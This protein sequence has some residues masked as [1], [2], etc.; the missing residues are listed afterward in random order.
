MISVFKKSAILA[1]FSLTTSTIAAGVTD[2]GTLLSGQ[3]NL[4]T[5]YKLIQ[6]CQCFHFS[7]Q[8]IALRHEMND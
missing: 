1:I 2:L 4:T 5:F 8:L 6:V 7:C 3:K